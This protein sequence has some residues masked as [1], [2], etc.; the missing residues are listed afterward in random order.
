[1]YNPALG[2]FMQRD[3]GPDGMMA[4]PTRVA[5]GPAATGGG[6]IPRDPTEQYADGMN[7]QQYARSAPTRFTDP[8]GL[9]TQCCGQTQYDDTKQ[10][11]KNNKD[12]KDLYK[13]CI[14]ANRGHAW[15]HAQDLETGNENSYGTNLTANGV[16]TSRG[17]DA[18][19]QY[20]AENCSR[21]CDFS[22]NLTAKYRPVG[23]N[24]SS[25]AT[26]EYQQST[27]IYINPA[28]YYVGYDSPGTVVD[29]VTRLNGGNATNVT[30]DGQMLPPSAYGV[31][32]DSSLL[33]LGSLADSP[34]GLAVDYVLPTSA[35]QWIYHHL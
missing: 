23:G 7:L 1:M 4:S 35:T 12:V 21:V 33:H 28:A 22:P 8:S 27:G 3:P 10:C 25:Y 32:D 6:F 24:C 15:I 14:R 30:P 31:S 19:G 29:T 26:D 16:Q 13:V 9:K 20:L 17:P 34:L 18:P 5:G 11:C 2:A